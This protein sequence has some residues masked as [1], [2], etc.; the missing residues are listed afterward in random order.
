MHSTF[1]RFSFLSLSALAMRSPDASIAT[2]NVNDSNDAPATPATSPAYKDID[3]V[4]QRE[5]LTKEALPEFLGKLGATP[6]IDKFN[7]ISPND[8]TPEDAP[9]WMF[10]K[11]G[12]RVEVAKGEKKVVTRALI[13]TPV[14]SFTDFLDDDKGREWLQAKYET[15]VNHKLMLRIRGMIDAGTLTQDNINSLPKTVEEFAVT[16]RTAADKEDL[17]AFTKLFPKIWKSLRTRK[18]WARFN[19]TPKMLRQALASKA[20]AAALYPEIENAEGGSGFL[21]VLQAFK[22]SVDLYNKAKKPEEDSLSPAIFDTW[23]ASRD[24]HVLDMSED[25][26]NDDADDFSVDV[27]DLFGTDDTKQEQPQ[28]ESPAAE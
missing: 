4:P 27:S 6:G 9:L 15:E 28:T 13:L 21:V 1:S 26:D 23:L 22:Q 3:S 14:P 25:D 24:S 2:G 12:E 19:F 17:A 10:A 5:F 18:A 11:L 16:T 20:H 7:I 8:V